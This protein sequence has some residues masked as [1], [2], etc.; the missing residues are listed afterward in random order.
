MIKSS[1][2]LFYKCI[3]TKVLQVFAV[4]N[5]GIKAGVINEVYM[6]RALALKLKL[7][8]T[9]RILKYISFCLVLIFSVSCQKWLDV[10]TDPNNRSEV[11]Y[12][13]VLPAGISSV[14]YVMGGR[15]Q[16]LGALWSQHWTQSVGAS[17]YAGIDSYD[18]NS[19]SFDDRQYGELYSGALKALEYIKIESAKEQEWNYYLI[20]NVMQVYTYQLLA[21]LYNEIP[22]SEALKGDAGITSPHFEK[23][24]D[25]YDSLI[26]RLDDALSKNFDKENL[27]NPKEQDILFQGDMD[28][29]I[30][31][32]NTLKL[33]IYLRQSEVRPEVAKAGIEKLYKDKAKFLSVDAAM[34]TFQDVSGSRNPLYETDIIFF[35]KNPNLVL[36]TTLYKYL[37]DNGDFYRLDHMFATPQNGGGHKASIQGNYN[38]SNPTYGTNS[39]DFSKPIL[40]A[41]DPV[42]LMS[43]SEACFLQAEAIIRYN[44]E[45]YAKAKENYENA[46]NSAFVRFYSPLIDPKAQDAAKTELSGKYKFPSEGSPLETFIKSI[47][48]QKW[49]SLA[50][51]QS[52]ET[53]FE[54]NRTHYPEDSPVAADNDNYKAGEF[55][56]SVNNVTSGKFPKRLIY[57]ESEYTGNPYTPEKKPVWEN[58]WWDTKP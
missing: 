36:S 19:S 3:R 1:S 30:E 28:R 26:V 48:V 57:P 55:T 14:A 5:S 52:L 49:V 11:D 54:H 16:V 22:F 32:A 21:D 7:L 42:Y 51:I 29:W 2:I 25:I 35:G 38:E 10:N 58:I 15:Y 39:A 34:T 43:Y 40:G 12:K 23:G 41:V 27:K 18:I 44:V 8:Q 9:N 45:T 17:Q 13:F 56:I 6:I 47:I 50:G 33:K 31:F 53:F 4:I 46:V 24:Q 37:L 20:S